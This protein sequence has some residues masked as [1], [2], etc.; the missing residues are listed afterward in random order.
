MAFEGQ[1][2]GRQEALV[3]WQVQ[4]IRDV[5]D[6]LHNHQTQ[7]IIISVY[8]LSIR[9]DTKFCRICLLLSQDLLV[10]LQGVDSDIHIFCY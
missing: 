8:G 7:M 4:P 9:V 3:L 10:L 1:L 6:V 5:L 2:Q